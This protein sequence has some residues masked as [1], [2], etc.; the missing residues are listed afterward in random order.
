MIRC[1]VNNNLTPPGPPIMANGITSQQLSRSKSLNDISNDSQISVFASDRFINLHNNGIHLEQQHLSTEDHANGSSTTITPTALTSFMPNY[2]PYIYNQQQNSNNVYTT[3]QFEH[4]NGI[5]N[6]NVYNTSNNNNNNN[7]LFIDNLRNLNSIQCSRQ[8]QPQPPSPP[9]H[10][11]PTANG[12]AF[13]LC[14][15]LASINLNGVTEQ[16]GNLHL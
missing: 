3:H 9:P 2:S 15:T 1:Q 6:S 10:L 12:N 5:S 13:N 11:R 8:Q 16:I 7:P 4:I 14:N